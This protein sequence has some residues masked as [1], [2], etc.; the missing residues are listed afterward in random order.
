MRGEKALHETD[1]VDQ[2]QPESEAQCAAR[3]TQ[4]SIEPI[5]AMCGIRE[6]NRD[7]RR[8]EHHPGNRA[9][10]K[11]QK[12]HNSPRRARNRREHQQR[13]GRGSG[14]A[15]HDAYDQR[16]EDLIQTHAS[17]LAVHPIDARNFVIVLVRVGCAS[18]RMHVPR[19]DVLL[20]RE[21]VF[22]QDAHEPHQ[23]RRAEQNQ[24][25]AD[26]PFHPQTQPRRDLNPEQYDRHAHCGNRQRVTDAPNNSNQG[27]TADASLLADN[28]RDG[29]DV[30]RVRGVP[31]PEEKPQRDNREQLQTI[32]FAEP[33]AGDRSA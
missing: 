9:N 14:Q 7:R 13:N 27:R 32:S 4:I 12:I 33:M 1:V 23:I 8:D 17:E 3:Q 28:R 10:P 19:M 21:R 20:R 25:Q 31:H 22:R 5:H 30:I 6:W 26:G 24:H 2:K 11:N 15:V 16:P 18:M 29:H